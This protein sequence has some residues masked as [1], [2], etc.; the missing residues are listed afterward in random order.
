[1]DANLFGKM[2]WDKMISLLPSCRFAFLNE[3]SSTRSVS[4]G[5]SPK[6]HQREE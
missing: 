6:T 5:S 1:M 4:E 3:P 2:I